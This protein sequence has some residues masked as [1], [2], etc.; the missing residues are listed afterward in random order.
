MM[1]HR[2]FSPDT[3][4]GSNLGENTRRAAVS[5]ELEGY[6]RRRKLAA[7]IRRKKMTCMTSCSRGN[8][9]QLLRWRVTICV[10]WLKIARVQLPLMNGWTLSFLVLQHHPGCQN[11]LTLKKDLG[12]RN[13]QVGYTNYC[14][15]YE[16]DRR[17]DW[18]RST[19]KLMAKSG[20]TLARVRSSG[21]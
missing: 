17:N 4:K 12:P 19:T 6:S 5:E 1:L 9:P 11:Q 21:S 7:Q 16:S 15:Y 14:Q 8:R 18:V 20:S 3:S 13:Q 2:G 10:E